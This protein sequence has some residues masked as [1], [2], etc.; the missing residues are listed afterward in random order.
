MVMVEVIREKLREFF[1][2][3]A[4]SIAKAAA[5]SLFKDDNLPKEKLDTIYEELGNNPEKPDPWKV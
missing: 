2:V 3:D 1:E 4:A 5:F